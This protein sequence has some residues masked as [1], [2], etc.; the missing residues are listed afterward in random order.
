MPCLNRWGRLP[1]FS[2]VAEAVQGPALVVCSVGF[3][4][5]ARRGG[6]FVINRICRVVEED[7][8]VFAVLVRWVVDSPAGGG[9]V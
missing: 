9:L 6:A 1:R 5:V 8:R 3:P 7:V 4:C 2:R